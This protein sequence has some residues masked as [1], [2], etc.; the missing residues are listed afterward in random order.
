MKCRITLLGPM[1][2]ALLVMALFV[3]PAQAAFKLMLSDGVVSVMVEDNMLG[4]GDATTGVIAF[5]GAVGT[6]FTVNLTTGLSK[7]VLPNT[8]GRSP[9]R[10]AIRRRA[11][12]AQSGGM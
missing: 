6:N 4:D 9:G 12:R 3:S 1:A 5:S 8:P 2:A 10:K 7:P 11:G